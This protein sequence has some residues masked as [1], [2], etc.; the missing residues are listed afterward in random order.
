MEGGL[1][2]PSVKGPSCST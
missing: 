2:P 1:S